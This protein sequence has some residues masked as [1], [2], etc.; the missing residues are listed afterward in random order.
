MRLRACIDDP[1]AYTIMLWL[2]EQWKKEVCKQERPEMVGRELQL[3]AFRRE[4]ALGDIDACVVEQEV[5]SCFRCQLFDNGVDLGCGASD[6]SL[7]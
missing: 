7:R 5:K 3:D 2:E 1:L 4:L 6:R